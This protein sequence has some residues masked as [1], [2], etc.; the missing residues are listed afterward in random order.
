MKKKTQNSKLMLKKKSITALTQLS[1]KGGRTEAIDELEAVS[2][3]AI[4]NITRQF[5][6][7]SQFNYCFP[8]QRCA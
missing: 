2:G 7:V 5:D 3:R 6:C 1:V 8:S 4:C